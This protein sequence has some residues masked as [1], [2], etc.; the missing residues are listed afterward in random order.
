MS[1]KRNGK[2]RDIIKEVEDVNSYEWGHLIKVVIGVLVF[3]GLFYLLTVFILNKDSKDNSKDNDNNSVQIQHEEI[4]IGTSF[5]ISDSE[6]YVLYYDVNDEDI[7][8]DMALLVS[9]YRSKNADITLY[10]VNMS[11]ALNSAF[12]NEEGNREATK[13]S[14]L[15]IAGPTLIKFADGKI[16]EYIEGV[17]NISDTLG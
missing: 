15:A 5:S 6:Y 2:K 16:G 17:D 7:S 13:A 10:T 11:D 8:S 3:L 1:K 12:K 9:N 14:E 4:L